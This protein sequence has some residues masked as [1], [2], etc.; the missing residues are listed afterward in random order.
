MNNDPNN[1]NNHIFKTIFLFGCVQVFSMVI[2]GVIAKIVAE[3]K[4][5]RGLCLKSNNE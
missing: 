5:S 3:P 1:S 4:R 2:K